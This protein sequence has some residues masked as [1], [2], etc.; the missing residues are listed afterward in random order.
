MFKLFQVLFDSQ[1]IIQSNLNQLTIFCE[2]LSSN[3]FAL[4]TYVDVYIT[5]IL[6]II[7][8]LISKKFFQNF[9]YRHR[10]QQQIVERNG[11]QNGPIENPSREVL[12][13]IQLNEASLLFFSLKYFEIQF[14][15]LQSFSGQKFP[16]VYTSL[17]YD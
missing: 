12:D 4:P 14:L 10:G 16:S 5:E 7:I 1:S 9:N 6:V 11:S 2:N 13:K 15:I 3:F 17:L 8:F